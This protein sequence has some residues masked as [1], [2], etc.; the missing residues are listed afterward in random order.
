MDAMKVL[1]EYGADINRADSEGF[2]PLL[3]AARGGHFATINWLMSNGTDVCAVAGDRDALC[4]A[5]AM[6]PM[7]DNMYKVLAR[8]ILAGASLESQNEIDAPKLSPLQCAA[9]PIAIRLLIVAGAEP[10]KLDLK[11]IF[12]N[13]IKAK[14]EVLLWE[15]L[16]LVEEMAIAEDILQELC[17]ESEMEEIEQEWQRLLWQFCHERVIDLA[18]V[19][20]DLPTWIIAEICFAEQKYLKLVPLHSV[21]D[22]I[23][24]VKRIKQ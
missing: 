14:D 23:E 15:E 6:W 20:V 21:I 11:F 7:G 24:K 4:W 22:W 17:L 8:L 13:V 10:T 9:D 18:M 3:L 16:S 19:F 5:A 2:T 1:A 12:D